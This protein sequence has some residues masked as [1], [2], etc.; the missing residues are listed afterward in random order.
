MTIRLSQEN[1]FGGKRHSDN[2][3]SGKDLNPNTA[4]DENGTNITMLAPSPSTFPTVDPLSLNEQYHNHDNFGYESFD[5]R[6]LT[7]DNTSVIDPMDIPEIAP[8]Q[9]KLRQL[10]HLVEGYYE[11]SHTLESYTE[12]DP[13]KARVVA[14]MLEQGR[15]ILG[16]E[17]VSLEAYSPVM[18]LSIAREGLGST[19]KHVW[20]AIIRVVKRIWEKIISFFKVRD[21]QSAY[22]EARLSRLEF[23]LN[24]VE[25]TTPVTA[26][27]AVGESYQKL[28][29]GFG[30][31]HGSREILAG[32]SEYITMAKRVMVEYTGHLESVGKNLVTAARAPRTSPEAWVKG[33]NN[34][35]RQFGGERLYEILGATRK[36]THPQFPADI[37]HSTFTLIGGRVILVIEQPEA[38][39]ASLATETSNLSQVQVIVSYRTD[40]KP[41]GIME[42]TPYGVPELKEMIKLA[43]QLNHVTRE[44]EGSRI[45]ERLNAIKNDLSRTLEKIPSEVN[46]HT[47]EVARALHYVAA[48]SNWTL[49]PLSE[50]AASMQQIATQVMSFVN[51]NA[52]AYRGKR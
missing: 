30:Q 25:G 16:T 33:M 29:K 42:I 15:R 41:L 12:L 44:H 23:F 22:I 4:L 47:D 35:A 10:S 46:S 18:T 26:I 39:D 1:E 34:A 8:D 27:V 9:L 13:S 43:R 52:Q 36:I 20:D 38:S 5:Q 21:I 2:V 45:V 32:L 49:H 11:L 31:P 28:G 14:M 24:G 37:V 17:Q 50:M 19:I 40:Y 6:P 7:D 51:A 48:L 3:S